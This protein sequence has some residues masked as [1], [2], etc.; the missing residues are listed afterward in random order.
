MLLGREREVALG[1]GARR[2]G[3][4]LGAGGEVD[5]GEQD[6]RFPI[7]PQRLVHDIRS[8]MDEHDIIALDTD[9]LDET[10]QLRLRMLRLDQMSFIARSDPSDASRLRAIAALDL[11]SR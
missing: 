10:I 4:V 11:A 7:L 1:G 6:D 5:E 9:C 8:V 2:I 3:V